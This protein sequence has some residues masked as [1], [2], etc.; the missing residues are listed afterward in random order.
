L[1]ERGSSWNRADTSATD[2]KAEGMAVERERWVVFCHDL[3]SPLNLILGY[4]AML[5]ED[6]ASLPEWATR[7]GEV[8]RIHEA[9]SRLLAALRDE[10]TDD[11]FGGE[12]GSFAAESA[13]V[14]RALRAP[15]GAVVGAADHLLAGLVDAPQTPTFS[16]D[17]HRIRDAAL[18]FLAKLDELGPVEELGATSNREPARLTLSPPSIP[19]PAARPEAGEVAPG[20][21]LVV[22]DSEGNRDVLS[23][24][25]TRQGHVV[26]L[27]PCGRDALDLLRR[28]RFDVVLLDV[29]MPDLDGYQVLEQLKADPEL[30]RIP[31][32]MIS[33]RGDMDSVVRCIELGAEDYLPK[34][35]NPVL[36]RARV[37]SSLTQKRL[38]DREQFY[39]DQLHLAQRRSEELLLNVLPRGIVQRLTSGESA[40][41]DH[42][43]NVTV[44][45]ADLVGFTAYA[46]RLAPRTVVQRLNEIFSAFDELVE[47]HGVEK[48]KTIGDG[49]LAVGGLPIARPDHADAIADLAIDMQDAVARFNQRTGERLVIRT[50]INSGP[51]V[52]GIIGTSRFSYD[53][54][55][56]TVNT[57]S[58]MESHGLPG[59]IHISEA[60]RRLLEARYVTEPRGTM[61]VKGKGP[62]ATHLLHR[63]R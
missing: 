59:A 37:G 48:I 10:P 6:T 3:R 60:T 20:K 41:A 32:I 26:S 52:A 22:D 38:R 39:L 11:G 30:R 47:R 40:I 13:S 42:F 44:L 56:D 17:L 54:W 2:G 36:L 57:A 25:L 35:F 46:A 16:R 1:L 31:V 9:G 49:Y 61:E 34:P 45:F 28:E 27:A 18:R 58:R 19:L 23:R 21:L 53:L 63:R 33:A 24:R 50:G 8:K 5:I 14:R 7:V 12:R 29:M 62:M 4:S 51:V 43:E 15:I 55:G